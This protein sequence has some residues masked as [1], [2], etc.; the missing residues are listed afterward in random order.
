MRTG[1]LAYLFGT[2]SAV[3]DVEQ[4]VKGKLR[5]GEQL[6]HSLDD[7]TQVFTEGED[8]AFFL[9]PWNDEILSGLEGTSYSILLPV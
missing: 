2:R 5:L 9:R 7:G 8:V 1:R 3:K 6:H 4:K